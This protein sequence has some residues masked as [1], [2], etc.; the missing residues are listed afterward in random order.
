VDILPIA[1]RHGVAEE[2]MRH[3]FEYCIAWVE[4]GDDPLRYL[5]AGPDQAGNFVE[6]VVVIGDEDELLIHTMPLRRG[7]A[8]E[9]FGGPRE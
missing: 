2:D 1:H 3:A 6:L 7:T 4:L 8:E 9:L 5:M